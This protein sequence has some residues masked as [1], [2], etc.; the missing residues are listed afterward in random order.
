MKTQRSETLPLKILAILISILIWGWIQ[1]NEEETDVK[2]VTISYLTPE[3]L[4]QSEELPKSISVELV[5][6]KGRIRQIKD[7][8]LNMTLDLRDVHLGQNQR[9]LQSSTLT[10]LPDGIRVTRFSPPILDLPFDNP[11]IREIP[12]RANILGVPDSK[13]KISSI[14]VNPKSISVKGPERYLSELE[15]ISTKAINIADVSENKVYSSQI[16]LPSSNLSIN[17]ANLI[18]VTIELKEKSTVSV[19]ENL[20]VVSNHF[21]WEI[22]PPTISI[23]VESEEDVSMHEQLLVNV[24]SLLE[25]LNIKEQIDTQSIT[26]NFNDHSDLFTLPTEDQYTIRNLDPTTLTLQYVNPTER[27]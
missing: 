7:K 11:S 25:G 16:S 2:R 6:A 9:T 5:G 10:D 3:K 19:L 27:Q 26:I 14:Q 21:D 1:L 12:I 20:Q 23:L 15:Y 17:Q 24:D 22:T 18:D 4:I 13:Y 8:R